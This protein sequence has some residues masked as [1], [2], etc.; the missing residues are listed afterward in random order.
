MLDY[1]C[2]TL[3]PMPLWSVQPIR[4]LRLIKW[5]TKSKGL[6]NRQLEQHLHQNRKGLFFFDLKIAMIFRFN[7]YTYLYMTINFSK[8]QWQLSRYA[9]LHQPPPP[10]PRPPQTHTH[11]R[12]PKW[13]KKTLRVK[14]K[15]CQAGSENFDFGRYKKKLCYALK[16]S[17][18][19]KELITCIWTTC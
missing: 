2:R 1:Q 14:K 15:V 3:V 6:R 19:T 18:C 10:S 13:L 8:V 12:T 11:T 9:L 16:L 17:K 5:E 4:T 7:A